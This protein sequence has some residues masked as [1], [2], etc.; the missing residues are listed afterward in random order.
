MIQTKQQLIDAYADNAARAITAQVHRNAVVSYLSCTGQLTGADGPLA[1]S[2]AAAP[3]TFS[4]AGAASGGVTSDVLFDYLDIAPG[5]DGIY[6]FGFDLAFETSVANNSLV[7]VGLY[8][9]GTMLI[10]Q[11]RVMTNQNND[12][13]IGGT[14]LTGQLVA[15]DRVQLGIRCANAGTIA[16]GSGLMFLARQASTP[17]T[18]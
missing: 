5:G 3:V 1:L 11:P 7:Y 15:T 18:A 4:A 17:V 6:L 2:V 12:I 13:S 14:F 9:N 8:L 10:E 16:W